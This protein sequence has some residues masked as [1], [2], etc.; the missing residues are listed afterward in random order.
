MV[1]ATFVVSLAVRVEVFVFRFAVDDREEPQQECRL[2]V[3]WVYGIGKR[4]YQSAIRL[5]STIICRPEIWTCELVL[6]IV[7]SW[8]SSGDHLTLKTGKAP[9]LSGE[10][11]DPLHSNLDTFF[12]SWIGE[13]LDRIDDLFNNGTGSSV[14]ALLCPTACECSK[15]SLLTPDGLLPC[16]LVADVVA[17]GQKEGVC[18]VVTTT[19][20]EQERPEYTVGNQLRDC[21]CDVC[22]ADLS[23]SLGLVDAGVQR[24]TQYAPGGWSVA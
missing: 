18:F 20:A 11:D 10:L 6:F 14:D 16:A 12:F 1:D 2:S 9:R 5:V 23:G 24:M 17:H 22:S 7:Q 13:V 21:V 15:K 8:H 4:T 19:Q 3:G